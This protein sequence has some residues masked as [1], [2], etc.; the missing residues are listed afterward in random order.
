MPVIRPQNKGGGFTV[1]LTKT[2]IRRFGFG[3]RAWYWLG[4]RIRGVRSGI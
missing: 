4:R 3:P 1:F 2:L